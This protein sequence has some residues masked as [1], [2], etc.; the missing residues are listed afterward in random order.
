M[1]SLSG[2]ADITTLVGFAALSITSEGGTADFVMRPSVYPVSQRGRDL[3][4]SE[5]EIVGLGLS[6]SYCASLVVEELIVFRPAD[7]T[8]REVVLVLDIEGTF[9]DSH[10]PGPRWRIGPVSVR[11]EDGVRLRLRNDGRHNLRRVMPV[12]YVHRVLA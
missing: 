8:G 1:N 6:T 5:F 10:L 11:A 2:D 12:L 4:N 7:V 3:C 9:F